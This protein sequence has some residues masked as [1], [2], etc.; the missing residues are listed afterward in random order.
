LK[1]LLDTH[2][3]LWWLADDP[4][5]ADPA[6]GI[7]EDPA[8]DIVV[9]VVSHW[10]I[11]AKI[12]IGKLEAK[13]TEIVRALESQAFG[14]LAIELA[15]LKTLAD[16]PLHHRDPFDH[17]LIAQAISEDMIFMTADRHAALYP[18]RIISC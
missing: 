13:I 18:A 15:H 2:A 11:T 14:F 7:I 6:R 1:V 5:L 12:R 17:L 10:E 3:V 4:R 9:S 16:L 8:N